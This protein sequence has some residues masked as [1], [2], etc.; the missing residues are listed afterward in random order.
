MI[1]TN[2]AGLVEA[3]S[4]LFA[5][6]GLRKPHSRVVLDINMIDYKTD[7]VHVNLSASRARKRLNGHGL[8]VRKVEAADRKQ[9]VILNTAI[10]EHLRELKSLFSDVMSSEQEDFGIP[11]VTEERERPSTGTG[12]ADC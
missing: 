10:G 9:A 4:Q 12:E 11:K 3:R 7:N 2:E 6:P 8:G 1:C 5:L